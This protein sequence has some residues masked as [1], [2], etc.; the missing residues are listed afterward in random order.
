MK[1]DKENNE[2]DPSVQKAA[3]NLR[4]AYSKLQNAQD[5]LVKAT[6]RQN[7]LDELTEA[8]K[9]TQASELKNSTDIKGPSKN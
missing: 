1:D 7:V 9:T 3:D 4:E 2:I 8:V 5:P 6:E